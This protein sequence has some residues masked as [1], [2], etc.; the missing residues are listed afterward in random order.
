[1]KNVKN[2]PV[3]VV[4]T[5]CLGDSMFMSLTK[6]GMLENFDHQ[7]YVHGVPDRRDVVLLLVGLH[8]CVVDFRLDIKGREMFLAC[9][10]QRKKVKGKKVENK[11]E[12]AGV[13]SSELTDAVDGRWVRTPQMSDLRS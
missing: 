6:C 9:R 4:S 8:Y 1:M 11:D 3:E 5:L 13:R 12:V 10:K 7:I 2:G